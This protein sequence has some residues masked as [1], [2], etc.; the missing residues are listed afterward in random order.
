MSPTSS[1]LRNDREKDLALKLN[2]GKRMSAVI[3][4]CGNYRYVLERDKGKKPLVFMMLN[5]STADANVDDP[6]IRRCRRFASDNGYS[7][8]VVVNLFAFR[9]TKPKDLF[10]AKD[11]IGPMNEL[12]ISEKTI[13]QDVC[14]AWGA[15]APSDRVQAVKSV[16]AYTE[17]NTLCL[18]ITK[19]GAPRHPL[20]VK[21]SQKLVSYW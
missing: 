21:A 14:C 16:L 7:G 9:A 10:A 1:D 6:T 17:A 3:S 5:P 19:S 2:R 20:Y 8:I 11:P 12:Y 4:D 18:G 15:N 13:Q